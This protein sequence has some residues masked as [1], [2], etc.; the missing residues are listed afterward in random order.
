MG[1]VPARHI[2]YRFE[3]D[4]IKWLEDIKW[5]E[6]DVKWWQEYGKFFHDIKL[7]REKIEEDRKNGKEC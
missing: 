2:R 6:K 3:K 5:W 1:G 7:L 4:D